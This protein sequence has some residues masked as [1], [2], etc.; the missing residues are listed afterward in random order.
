MARVTYIAA[1]NMIRSFTAGKHTVV[2]GNTVIYK[3]AMINSGWC[4]S[5]RAMTIAT[6]LSGGD[7]I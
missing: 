1:G 7:M 2:T 4:P 3:L 6:F 5:L